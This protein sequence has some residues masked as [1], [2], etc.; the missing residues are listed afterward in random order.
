M[1]VTIKPSPEKVSVN[2][3]KIATSSRDLLHTCEQIKHPGAVRFAKPVPFIVLCRRT[4][5]S[6]FKDIDEGTAP[7]VIPYANGFFEGVVRAYQQDLY[8]VLRPDDVWQAVITQFSFYVVGNAEEL[9]HVFVAHESKKELVLENAGSTPESMN[10]ASV[11]RKLTYL[12]EEHLVDQEMRNWII[13]G[14]STTTDNDIAVASVTM[15]ATMQK[16]FSYRANSGCGFPSVTLLGERDDW[17]KMR[18]RLGLLRKYGK[19][20]EEWSKLLIPIFDRFIA[21]FDRPNDEDLRTFWLTVC[22]A[23]RNGSG[24]PDTFSGWMTTFAFWKN[25]GSRNWGVKFSDKHSPWTKPREPQ[26]SLDGQAYPGILQDNIPHGVVKVPVVIRDMERGIDF[27]TQ[28]IA[29]SVGMSVLDESAEGF[30]VQPRSGWW[31]LFIR[32][33]SVDR[34]DG[35]QS[36]GHTIR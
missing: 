29:G 33:K 16:Y 7:K 34:S 36:V 4:M 9:R 19:Q 1:P 18:Q 26:L 21:T 17:V 3:D 30:T 10:V 31:M 8:L 6:S 14:F 22:H 12:I 27:H 20:P 13:P 24:Q 15:M 35:Q 32:Q 23:E 11:A 5:H 2:T 28:L 25:D